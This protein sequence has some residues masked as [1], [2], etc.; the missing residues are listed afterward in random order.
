VLY[1]EK[2]KVYH[3]Y[4]GFKIEVIKDW[5]LEATEKDKEIRH[6]LDILSNKY[7]IKKNEFDNKNLKVLKNKL[8][9]KEKSIIDEFMK[10]KDRLVKL[11]GLLRY[12]QK[13]YKNFDPETSYIIPFTLSNK[14][15]GVLQGLQFPDNRPETIKELVDLMP[16]EQRLSEKGFDRNKDNIDILLTCHSTKGINREKII[17]IIEKLQSYGEIYM[18]VGDKLYILREDVT[19]SEDFYDINAVGRRKELAIMKYIYEEIE[20]LTGEFQLIFSYVL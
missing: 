3:A 1:L 2:K 11:K 5:V 6:K 15:Y 9:E 16:L 14:G 13:K 18:Y 12:F 19:R 4:M 20:K 17:F 10:N 7:D 8:G